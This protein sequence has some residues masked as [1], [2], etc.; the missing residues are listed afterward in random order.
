V[1][2]NE[3]L[4]NGQGMTG[5]TPGKGKDVVFRQCSECPHRS[6]LRTMK[7]K[8]D[9]WAAIRTTSKA[10][11]LPLDWEYWFPEC[12]YMRLGLDTKEPVRTRHL[13][14]YAQERVKDSDDARF[15]E[16]AQCLALLYYLGSPDDEAILFE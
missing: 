15:V 3:L 9:L 11:S 7:P 2:K 16:A 13:I 1:G 12:I 6:K 4:L 5:K 10:N 14:E 8:S